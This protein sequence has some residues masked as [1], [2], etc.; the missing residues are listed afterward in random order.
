MKISF[1]N[2]LSTICENIPNSNVDDITKALG[3][4]KRISPYYLKGGLPFAGP[5]FPRDNRAF[6][7]FAKEY[8]CEANLAVATDEVNDT[9]VNHITDLIVT[10]VLKTRIKKVA[11]IGLAYKKDTNVL[12]ESPAIKVIK[13]L[14]KKK[15]KVLVYD[16]LAIDNTRKVFGHELEYLTGVKEC[17]KESQLICIFTAFDEIKNINNS[18]IKHNP[19]T[20]ID[21][22]RA[23]DTSKLKNIKYIALG[24]ASK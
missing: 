19:T 16:P 11:V 8:G 9:Q 14:L 24:K 13:L 21:C 15:I 18:Y 22:W 3:A 10:N 4:D 20:I 17:F 12:D 7:V 1:A 6:A 5:C 23:I 2:T